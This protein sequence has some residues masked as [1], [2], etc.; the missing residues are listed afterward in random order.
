[1]N[2][3]EREFQCEEGNG[4]D[5]TPL[6]V[7]DTLWGEQPVRLTGFRCRELPTD[8]PTKSAH[9]VAFHAGQVLV[10]YDISGVYGYPGG[11]LESGESCAEALVREVYEEANAHL[12]SEFKLFAALKIE[13]T[14]HLPGKTY[15][16]T[17]TYMAFYVGEV[18]A[19]EDLTDDP[20]GIIT[21]RALFTSAEC[22]EKLP[23]HDI[24]L[25]KEALR[26]LTF[27][28]K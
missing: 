24:I 5:K 23:P 1:M 3:D 9:I 11:R 2:A 17:H 18:R 20:A 6:F 22:Q 4:V 26:V 10:V 12:H 7:V 16:P 8:A 19:L 21:E 27:V 14:Q 15:P 25:L 28:E 13:F